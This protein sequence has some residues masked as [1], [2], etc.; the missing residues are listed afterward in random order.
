[1]ILIQY[2]VL[3]AEGSKY[4]EAIIFIFILFVVDLIWALTWRKFLPQRTNELCARGLC[5]K[6]LSS[7]PRKLKETSNI[8]KLD[9]MVIFSLFFLFLFYKFNSTP[10]VAVPGFILIYVVYIIMTFKYEIIDLKII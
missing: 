5:A 1:M 7:L 6:E 2:Y 3:Y 4:A 10:L 9:L 8:I